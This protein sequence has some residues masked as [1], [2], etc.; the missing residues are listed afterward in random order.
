MTALTHPRFRLSPVLGQNLT[1]SPTLYINE[2]VQEMWA[3]GKHVLHLGF[4]ES[5]FPVHP[6]LARALADNAHRKSYLPGPG[7]PELREA[8]AR[9]Y[10]RRLGI[11]V[12]P[13]Q[14]ITAPGSKA[15]LYAFQMA[16]DGDLILPV[17][18]WVSYAPQARLL[19]KEIQ[20][21]PAN[22][23]TG[24]DL[25]ID[26]L[27]AAVQRSRHDQH[28]LILTSPNNPSSRMTPQ[29]LL[30]HI[31][32]FCREANVL[33]L[34]DEIYGFVPH[35]HVRH[36]SI[37][38][39]YPEGT[40][41]LGGLSK[42]LSLGGWRLGVAVVPPGEAGQTLLRGVNKI[43]SEIWSCA[44]APVEYAAVVAYSG[45]PDIEAYI[46]ECAHLHSVRTQ[47]LWHALH[48][49]GIPCARPA[50]GFYLFPNFDRWREPLAA[51]GVHTSEELAR[52][53]LDTWHIATLPGSVFGT[54]P[55]ELSLRLSTSYVDMETDEKARRILELHRSGVDDET[56][57]R[58]HHPVMN[59][60]IR[61]LQQFLEALQNP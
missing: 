24:Q 56:L 37:V 16:I 52:Y 51:R 1:P 7:I 25:T 58:E 50:G 35:N 45:D 40:V 42:H 39:H 36:H 46:A 12:E 55:E 43:G 61:R 34:S 60:A 27:W 15:L 49:L 31:A 13:E 2:R 44:T 47:Y 22:P 53:L 33:V 32:A 19:H 21:V 28:T 41:V 3:A 6:K 26:N 11:H 29:E 48:E 57:M 18:T 38:A 30:P 5:R 54:A 23:A 59:E 14:V 4:G 9:F 17:P 20:W 8:V 10:G